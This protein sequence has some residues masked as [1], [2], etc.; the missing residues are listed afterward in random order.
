MNNEKKSKGSLLRNGAVQ[1]LLASIVCIIIGLLIGYVVLLRC[2][3]SH[4]CHSE[5]LYVLSVS[6]EGDTVLWKYSG[7]SV[8]IAAVFSVRIICLQGRTV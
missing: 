7:K 4:C 6:C 1:S 3:R 5:E 2:S 8:S